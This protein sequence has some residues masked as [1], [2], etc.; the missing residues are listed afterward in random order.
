MSKVAITPPKISTSELEHFSKVIE[1]FGGTL[2]EVDQENRICRFSFVDMKK[3]LHL[4]SG[5]K[6]DKRLSAKIRINSKI[7]DGVNILTVDPR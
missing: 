7:V 2:L 4:I 1:G 5:I 3:M 6:S